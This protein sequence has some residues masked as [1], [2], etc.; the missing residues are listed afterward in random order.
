MLQHLGGRPPR[1]SLNRSK[2]SGNSDGLHGGQVRQVLWLFARSVPDVGVSFRH[3]CS[4]DFG[5]D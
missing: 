2:R 5:R 1:D 3:G 4:I